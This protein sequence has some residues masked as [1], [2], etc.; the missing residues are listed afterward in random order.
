MPIS[1]A[2]QYM[3]E[4][5]KEKDYHHQISEITLFLT[6]L[7]LFLAKLIASQIKA[8]LVGPSGNDYSTTPAYRSTFFRF[9]QMRA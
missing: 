4:T 6:W 9:A 8:W 5:G 1:K 3:V 7:R 2:E